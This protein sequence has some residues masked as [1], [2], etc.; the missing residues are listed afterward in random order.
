MEIFKRSLSFFF[1][2]IVLMCSSNSVILADCDLFSITGQAAE[3][4]TE[5][6][7]SYIIK[8]NEAI[9]VACNKNASGLVTIPSTLGGY[10]V[11]TIY[12]SAFS[13][14]EYVNEVIIP[15][16]VTSICNGAFEDCTGLVRI[17]IPKSEPQ[18]GF[19]TFSGCENLREIMFYGNLEGLY[20]ASFFGCDSLTDI[21][22]GGS[23]SDWKNVYIEDGLDA[24]TNANMHFNYDVDSYTPEYEDGGIKAV[25]TNSTDSTNTADEQ[26]QNGLPATAI[27]GI[28]AA[29]VVVVAGVVAGIVL[30]KKKK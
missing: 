15:D 13:K 25:N 3:E 4:Q 5:G 7:L 12:S 2:V 18:I 6:V 9:I 17:R 22:Y 11:T 14:R 27:I 24:I 26:P 20:N 1:A 10:P 30:A 21:Y 16:G 23:E 29:A 28:A 19:G 8:D